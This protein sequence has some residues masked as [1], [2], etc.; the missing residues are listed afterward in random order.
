MQKP[1]ALKTLQT[2]LVQPPIKAKER[3]KAKVKEKSVK[4]TDFRGGES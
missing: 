1:R 3:A 2:M 4:V